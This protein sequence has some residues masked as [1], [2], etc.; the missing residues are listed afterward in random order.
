MQVLNGICSDDTT[1]TIHVEDVVA[2]F[3]STPS[4]SCS[5]PLTVQY[6]S[7]VSTAGTYQWIFGDGTTSNLA[8]PSHT[9]YRPD[10]NQYTIYDYYYYTDQLTFTSVHGCKDTVV[11]QK[12]IRCLVSLRVLC[13]ISPLAVRQ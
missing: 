13:P 6:T 4:Y 8:N 3:T 10:T 12:T 9:F 11:I 5:W 1:I 2:N 7:T